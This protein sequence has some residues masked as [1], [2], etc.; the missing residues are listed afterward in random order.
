VIGI[1]HQGPNDGRHF[2]LD[3]NIYQ[4]LTPD[5]VWVADH[6]VRAVVNKYAQGIYK[7]A[8]VTDGVAHYAWHAPSS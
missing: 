7:L 2:D 8:G 3:D 6:E 4:G 1:L 5:S